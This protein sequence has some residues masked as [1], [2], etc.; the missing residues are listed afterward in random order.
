MSATAMTA[1]T[2]SART[3]FAIAGGFA[4]VVGGLFAWAVHTSWHPVRPRLVC[5]QP[6]AN[7]QTAAHFGYANELDVAVSLPIGDDNM[8]TPG[9]PGRGQPETFGPRVAVGSFKGA[10]AVAFTGRELRWRLDG[11]EAVATPDSPRCPTPEPIPI[12]ENVAWV[13]PKP[14]EPPPPPEPPPEP[15]KPP[16]PEVKPE[17]PPDKPPEPVKPKLGTTAPRPK[18]VKPLEATPRPPEPV[19]LA[20][21][22]LTNL[23]SGIVVQAGEE[24]TLG[25][26]AVT[27]TKENTTPQPA[28]DPQ[29]DPDGQGT[30]PPAKVVRTPPKVKV[31][32][33]G[34]WPAD[35][36]PRAGAVLVKLSLFVDEDG[37]V[38]QVKVVK[39][40][41]A[42][43]DREAKRVGLQAV[44]APATEDGRPISQ[45]VPWVVEFT[46]EEG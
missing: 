34:E 5:V 28:G 37:K 25:D 43:F 3:R 9:E 38:S 39:G 32:P 14:L 10:F 8:F 46:P 24:T 1:T 33:R 29:G 11:R 16:E 27:A 22:D 12:R 17:P 30:A 31:R 6:L 36:P 7:G 44:F 15:P 21:A 13:K 26:A 45:W 42:A 19:P 23:S 4:L 18:P 20:V 41:G 40:A 2:P 35:A